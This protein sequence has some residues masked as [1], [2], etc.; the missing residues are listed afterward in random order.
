MDGPLVSYHEAGHAVIA[1]RLGRRVERLS[2]GMLRD[3]GE[4]RIAATYD[5]HVQALVFLAG[6]RAE[7][8]CISWLPGFTDLHRGSEDRRGADAALASL[9][10]C[11]R[12]E[13]LVAEVD[14]RLR[15]DW[16]ALERLA[17]LLDR[18]QRVLSGAQVA[19]LLA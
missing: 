13:D 3:T 18:E 14:E 8:R 11:C 6:E 9:G 2:V 16:L 19:E 5:P 7:M 4:T 12:V 15:N 10:G 1:H 17:K